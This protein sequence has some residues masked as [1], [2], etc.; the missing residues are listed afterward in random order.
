M[1]EEGLHIEELPQLKDP[2]L[3][4]AFHGWG[5]A[6]DVATSMVSYLIQ[7][8]DAVFFA[9]FRPDPYYRYDE[10]R[11]VVIIEDGI[12]K[13]L[14]PAGGFFFAARG[15]TVGRDLVILRAH[16]PQL[17]WEHFVHVLLS[18]CDRLGI[19]ALVTLGGMFDNVLHTDQVISGIAS[20]P[21]LLEK[22]KER[23]ILPINY[24]GPSAIH[25]TIHAEGKSRGLDC[26]SLWCHCPYYLQGETHYGLLSRL[27]SVLSDLGGFR[28]DTA[29]LD[30]KWKELTRQI[31]ELVDQ[32]P[33]LQ[34]MISQLRKAKVR[35][36]WETIKAAVGENNKVI[37]LDDFLKPR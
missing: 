33:E 32:N 19:R 28:L 4:A 23:D 10:N 12:L 22:M 17:R 15:E 7:K 20:T 14:I 37:R 30:K 16:E 27:G 2:L 29:E 9:R 24:Q 36:S 35:G 1:L 11:P 34:D 31:Q 26:F 21:E 18:L 3:I 13:H 25:S 8:T 6:L 5:N